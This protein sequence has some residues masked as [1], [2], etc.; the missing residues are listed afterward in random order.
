[1]RTND[2]LRSWTNALALAKTSDEQQGIFLHLARVELNTGH[3]EEASRM[4]LPV[5]D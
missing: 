2:A 4:S 5:E 3:F 1:M